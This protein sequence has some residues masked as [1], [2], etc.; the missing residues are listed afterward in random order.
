MIGM[1]Q[2]NEFFKQ[3]NKKISLLVRKKLRNESL[4]E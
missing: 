2:S 3:R 1:L 4:S